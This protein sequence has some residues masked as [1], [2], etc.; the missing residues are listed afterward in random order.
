M[1]AK[2]PPCSLS[3]DLEA[4]KLESCFTGD[5]VEHLPVLKWVENSSMKNVG[6]Q[7]SRLFLIMDDFLSLKGWNLS[8]MA[9]GDVTFDFLHSMKPHLLM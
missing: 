6:C 7:R 8:T 2:F 3:S 1:A 5:V 9:T 4:G